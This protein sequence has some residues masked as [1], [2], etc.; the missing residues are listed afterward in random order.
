MRPAIREKE[1]GM[2]MKEDGK[3]PTKHMHPSMY[4]AAKEGNFTALENSM[5]EHGKDEPRLDLLKLETRMG[6]NLVHLAAESGHE[7]FIKQ[8]LRKCP[9][10]VAK[11]NNSC[12]EF[13][14]LV[15]KPNNSCRGADTP[16]H[17]AARTRHFKVMDTILSEA[18]LRELFGSLIY[19]TV[20]Y[21]DI[22]YTVHIISQYMT[23][24]CTTN[25]AAVLRILCYANVEISDD[26]GRN[27]VHLALKCRPSHSKAVLR[28]PE[29]VRLVNKAN[30]YGNT[31]LHVAAEDLNYGM[32]KRLLK[33]P[34][35]DLEAKNAKG[36]TFRMFASLVGNTPRRR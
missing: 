11:P 29:L 5:R 24:P 17:I 25:F 36:C 2:K 26:K 9:E 27:A 13:A 34:G 10:L 14:Q 21:S 16:L 15:D 6:N 32:V 20:T 4:K 22:T 1:Q 31:P 7:D 30:R 33:I 18:K 19:L 12:H 28:L 8:V 3:P 35:V 23:V